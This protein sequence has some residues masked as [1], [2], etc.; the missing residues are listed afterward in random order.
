M[1]RS[2]VKRKMLP[3]EVQEG[4]ACGK[5]LSGSIFTGEY[6][7]YGGLLSSSGQKSGCKPTLP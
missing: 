6:T 4:G 5:E 2:V 3:R 7:T 1:Q